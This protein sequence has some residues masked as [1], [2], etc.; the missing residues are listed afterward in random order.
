MTLF[1]STLWWR[2]S[3][4]GWAILN[5]TT[6]TGIGRVTA[7]GRRREKGNSSSRNIKIINKS[8]VKFDAY[9]IHSQ[10][11]ELANSNS[12]GAG[13]SY[14][15]DLAINSYVGHSFAVQELPDK[16]T[17]KCREEECLETQFTVKTTE[18]QGAYATRTRKV[19]IVHTFID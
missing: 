3:L 7:A 18:D 4:L 5:S 11:G 12:N 19:K 17:H 15:A 1:S 14:G 8:G 13:V 10:T 16:Y 9:W 2:C 6:H